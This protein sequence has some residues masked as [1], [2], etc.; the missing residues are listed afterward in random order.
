M[1]DKQEPQQPNPK[2]PEREK[3]SVPSKP[4]VDESAPAAGK[5][6]AISP[7][8]RKFDRTYFVKVGMQVSAVLV[9]GMIVILMLAGAQKF[10]WIG[11]EPAAVDGANDDENRTYTCAMHPQI[12]QIGPGRCP[13]CSMKL[14]PATSL[15]ANRDEFAVSIDPAA[16]RLANIQTAKVERKTVY[17]TIETVGSIAFDE[18]RLATIAIYVDGRIEKLF[19]DYT[20]V[21][22]ARGDHLAVLYSPDLFSAQVE[23]LQSRKGLKETGSETLPVVRQGLQRLVENARHG[24]AE[25]GMT[26]EQI[27]ELERSNKAQIRLTVYSPIGGTVIEKLVDEGKY[28]KAGEPVYRIANL[29]M[30]WLMLQLYPEDATKIRFGQRVDAELQS[31][32]GEIFT[33]R[34]AFIDR[35]VNPKTRTVGVRVE[36]RN[37]TGRVRPGDYASAK[38]H[39]P[40]GAE[41]LVYDADLAGKWISP[42][43]P[44]I[45]R[46]QPGTCPICGMDLVST[47]RYGYSDKPVAQPTS[48][49]VPR[50]AV[51]MA[52]KNSVLYV[53]TIPGRFEIR[54]LVVGTITKDLAVILR[55]VKE[56]EMVATSG[57][58]LIDSQMQLAGNPSL[59]DPTRAI[60]RKTKPT[61]PIQLDPIHVEPMEG[62]SGQ[63]LERLYSAYFSIQTS[64]ASNRK[65][66]ASEVQNLRESAKTVLN[67][68]NLPKPSRTIIETVLAKSAH[69]H[70]M[71]L[72]QARE[73][74]KPVSQGIV[75]L[76]SQLRGSGAQQPFIHFYCPMVKG[77]G[78]DWLQNAEAKANPFHGRQMQS[79]VQKV[80]ELPTSGHAPRLKAEANRDANRTPR[81]K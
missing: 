36:V 34:V 62:E 29:E 50:D 73:Q 26:E 54:P 37:P 9:A 55:G 11:E 65:I 15:D 53:E 70:H 33:G 25:L 35:V 49:V 75:R 17:Q 39:V 20:G 21:K 6:P 68:G 10:G 38:I 1:T 57:N 16:R 78:G 5:P 30:V 67:A 41:G 27:V 2:P 13:I 14:V 61:G 72:E 71:N 23:Y 45:I 42:M 32:P 63:Q 47:S 74:F 8:D 76:A 58:F 44:Q 48:L 52:G 40:I 3:T 69:L 12:R 4:V 64:L 80:H 24:L 59:I 28:V 22:V 79:C 56:G 66:V 77:G 51:L 43:H 81:P 7:T 31:L 46:E 18:S 19:A 60:K